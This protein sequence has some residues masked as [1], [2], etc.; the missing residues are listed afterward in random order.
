MCIIL[1]TA[2]NNYL[3]AIG[4]YV[5]LRCHLSPFL[6][7]INKIII[8][9]KAGCDMNP[10]QI[11]AGMWLSWQGKAKEQVSPW[12]KASGRNGWL[13][14]FW[15]AEDVVSPE[16]QPKWSELWVGLGLL[17]NVFVNICFFSCIVLM[18]ILN[19][20]SATPDLPCFGLIFK[21]ISHQLITLISKNLHWLG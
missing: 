21:R 12:V 1:I 20:G 13:Y 18:T 3:E 7:T 16:S 2:H 15:Q 19:G 4:Y 14:F 9:A 5:S 11:I 17:S 8:V 10:N 6:L